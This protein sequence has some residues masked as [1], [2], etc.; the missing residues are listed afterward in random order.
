MHM[1]DDNFKHF[2]P[3]QQYFSHTAPLGCDKEDRVMVEQFHL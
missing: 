1:Y 2:Q 3:F